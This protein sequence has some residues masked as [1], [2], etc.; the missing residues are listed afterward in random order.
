VA[1]LDGVSLE[2]EPGE[3]FTLLGPSGCGKTTLLRT[4]AGFERQDAGRLVLGE[5]TLDDVPP[6]QRGVGLVFQSYALF[7]H[8]DVFENVA[9]GLRERGAAEDAIEAAVGRALATARL[10]GLGERRP[11]QL[12]GGQQQRVGIA[13]ALV[14]EPRLLLMDEPLSN[15]DAKL[16]VDMRSELRA[17][18]QAA[19]I[20][21]LYVTHDQEEALAISDRVAVLDAGRCQQVGP[22]EEVYR[23]PANRFVASFV[24]QMS[25]LQGPAAG[26]LLGE[27]P[28]ARVVGVRPEDLTLEAKAEGPLAGRVTASTF[29]GPLLRT[30]IDCGGTE[31][32][33]EE[34]RPD[35]GARPRP[36]HE[37]SLSVR[38]GGLHL[39]DAAGARVS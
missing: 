36:G 11:D 13:R 8:L 18:Q 5:Q 3:L 1:A 10:D 19:G 23:R 35:P 38:A 39:F 25:F 7:P 28:G 17:L 15:L 34:H 30:R 26:C 32:L 31:V 4:V 14:I 37:V 22:P 9:F 21:T 12:S 24:G 2:V 16:R 6:H 33:V 20:T 27:E 29:T